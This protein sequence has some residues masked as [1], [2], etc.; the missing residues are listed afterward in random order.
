M[1][2][3]TLFEM[4]GIYNKDV[5]MHSLRV[6]EITDIIAKK[7][8][9]KNSIRRDMYIGQLLHDIGMVKLNPELIKKKNPSFFEL[10]LVRFHVLYGYFL[11]NDILMKI[12]H[13]H[14]INIIAG[15]HQYFNGIGYNPLNIKVNI[16]TNIVSYADQID[17]YHTNHPEIDIELILKK[18]GADGER[19]YH[20]SILDMQNNDEFVKSLKE[21]YV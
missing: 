6:Q 4:V 17:S 10:K 8:Y 20:P 12:F 14:I 16:Y 19:L 5:Q 1:K 13:K 11:V 21:I 3:K 18:I 7:L 15:H 9:I 2:T